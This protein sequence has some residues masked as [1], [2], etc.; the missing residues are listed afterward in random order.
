M[1][2]KTNLGPNVCITASVHYVIRNNFSP[3]RYNIMV[4][5]VLPDNCLA[6]TATHVTYV[7][8][9]ILRYTDAGTAYRRHT[10]Y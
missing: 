3:R 7:I 9:T 4:H 8:Q 1:R 6:I 5:C 2:V 10:L